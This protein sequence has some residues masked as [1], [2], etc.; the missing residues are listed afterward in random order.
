[1]DQDAL[2]RILNTALDKLY[3]G[4][5]AIIKVD[6][7]ERTICARLAAILQASFK[8]HAVHAEYNRHG[9][10]P[11][12]IS[13]PNADG[14]LTGTRVFPDIIVHQPG[15]D[16]ENLLVIEVK[17]STN[18]L[19][20]EADLRKLE[21]IKEQIAYRFAVFLR[22]PAGQ[23]AARADVRMTW[24]GPQLRNLNS[25][26]ITEYPFPWPDEHKGYQVFPEAMEN[27]D[28]VAFH[29]TARAN[30]D[31]IINN[32]FQFA[33]SLQSLSFAKHSPSSLSH[34]CSRRSES[35][36]EGVVIAVRFAP[37]IPRP[38]IAVETSDIHVYRLNEQ[39]E[40][41]GYCNVPADY[42]LR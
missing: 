5:Q 11:K 30:L 36:P 35:S 34:A 25:A 4:D 19:P 2:E 7:A 12:E 3:A 31:S 8:D 28:L 15:H 1:M 16:D 37:P 13:L 41:I 29:G 24:V 20:D 23:D 9:V 21:K 33:G 10:D 22:L 17:K 42:V 32:G 14:V 40:V 38:Y 6:V 39:P 26:S 18:V 27:D